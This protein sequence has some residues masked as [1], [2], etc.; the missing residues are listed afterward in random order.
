MEV[1]ACLLRKKSVNHRLF[2]VRKKNTFRIIQ[3]METLRHFKTSGLLCSLRRD[4]TAAW[5]PG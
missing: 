5:V 4:A 1:V 2:S 3:G